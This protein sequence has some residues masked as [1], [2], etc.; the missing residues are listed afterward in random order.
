MKLKI[1]EKKLG[2]F[3]SRKYCLLTGNGTTSLYLCLKSL[4]LPKQSKVMIPNSVCP[5]VPLSIYLAGLK[6]L[7]VDIDK[8]N[9]SLNI[10]SIF[11]NYNRKVKVI[12]LC[13]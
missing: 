10:N 3:Y 6:P 4:N 7:F 1:V 2:K 9:L 8:R 13:Y 5:H 12:I 11:K